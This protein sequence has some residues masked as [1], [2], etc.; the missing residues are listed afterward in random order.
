MA[1]IY[2]KKQTNSKHVLF[3]HIEYLP[4]C[5]LFILFLFLQAIL[6]GR[7]HNGSLNGHQMATKRLAFYEHIVNGTSRLGNWVQLDL[8]RKVSLQDLASFLLIYCFN[9]TAKTLFKLYYL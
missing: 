5:A 4:L 2:L 3:L 1:E 6:S 9:Y 8:S 7:G